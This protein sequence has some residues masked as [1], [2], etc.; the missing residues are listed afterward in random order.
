MS[1][2]SDYNSI[3]ILFDKFA[4]LLIQNAVYAASQPLK[5]AKLHVLRFSGL[6][7]Q[8]GISAARSTNYYKI[9]IV[10]VFTFIL[11]KSCTKWLFVQLLHLL[12]P[13]IQKKYLN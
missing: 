6:Q 9:L 13:D 2:L 3:G 8:K 10:L 5:R 12:I 7:V 11:F 1:N 4:I